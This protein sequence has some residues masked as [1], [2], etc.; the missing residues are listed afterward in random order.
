MRQ[1]LDHALADPNNKTRFTLIF[2]NVTP[3]DILMKEDFDT[4]KAKYPDTFNV[5]YTVDKADSDW[6]G[7]HKMST[8]AIRGANRGG[9][10]P[11]GYV[12]KTLLQQHVP[13]ASLGD[14]VKILICGPPGQVAA[15][16]GKK[17]GMKQGD[18]G[19]LL[20]DLGYNEEQVC[21]SSPPSA[22]VLKDLWMGRRSSNFKFRAYIHIICHLCIP[23]RRS[24]LQQSN[25]L[26]TTVM[27]RP[28]QNH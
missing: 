5:V 21:V 26:V 12:N 1:I 4:L 7:S 22:R 25:L 17:D 11:T 8:M 9:A 15:I 18:V 27:S 10:G 14:K 20:K 13:P 16:A 6:K 2:A 24:L 3:K 19:G 28:K 23:N